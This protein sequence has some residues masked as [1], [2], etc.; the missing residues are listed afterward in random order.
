MAPL[1]IVG[2]SITIGIGLVALGY[3]S[4]IFLDTA[5]W[6]HFAKADHCVLISGD[7]YKCD[8]GIIT[9]R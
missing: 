5:R 3:L 7:Q 6:E 9:K 2:I 8:H 1:K 4:V